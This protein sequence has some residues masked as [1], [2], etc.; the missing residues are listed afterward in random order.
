MRGKAVIIPGIL[1][2][3]LT[4]GVRLLPRAIVRSVVR[5]IQE[6]R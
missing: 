5:F 4:V 6:R 3:S 1:N 2:K